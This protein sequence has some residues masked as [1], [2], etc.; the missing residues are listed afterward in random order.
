MPMRIKAANV[1]RALI[2]AGHD[3]SEFDGGDWDPGHR[4]GQAGPRVVHVFHDGPGEQ[5]HLALYTDTLRGL[6][7]HVVAQEQDGG[8]RRRLAV[9]R[10]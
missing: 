4:S 8:A 2:D 9:T 10:P 1:R 5:H 7:Y 6:G 3:F